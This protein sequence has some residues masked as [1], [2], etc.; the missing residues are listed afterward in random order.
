MKRHGHLFERICSFENLTAAAARAARGKKAKPG[1]ALFLQDIEDRVIELETSL[2]DKTYQPKPYRVFEICDPK[3][4]MICAADFRDRVVHH[5]LCNELEPLFERSY[6]HDTYACRPAKGTHAAVTRTQHFLRRFPYYLKLDIHKFFDS[7]DH[8]I[9]TSLIE[10][11]VKDPDAMWLTKEIIDHQVPWT[12]RGKGLPIGN[13]TSQHFANDYLSGLDHFVKEHLQVSGYLRY[14]D[15]MV[16]FDRQKEKLWNAAERL[17]RYLAEQL[18]LRI[19]EGTVVL[20]PSLQGLSFLGFRI[21]PGVIRIQRKGWRRFR[22]KVAY[23]NHQLHTDAIDEAQWSR[24][25]ASLVG[26]LQHAATR[27]LRA[28]FFKGQGQYEA[29]T[30]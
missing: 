17:E 6:I 25:M 5:A 1:V 9:L 23:R 26:H 10:R 8:A 30:A 24:A 19:K 16:L 15:D 18:A 7:V 28:A 3:E 11:K 21:F 27:N 2:K 14:M 13:L 22:R 4:R 12:P 29:T 20:A